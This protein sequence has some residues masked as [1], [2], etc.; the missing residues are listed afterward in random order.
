MIVQVDRWLAK[1]L[2]YPAYCCEF[3]LAD[4]G[5][6]GPTLPFHTREKSFLYCRTDNLHAVAELT[7]VGWILTETS[8]TLKTAPQSLRLGVSESFSQTEGLTD[9]RTA[10]LKDCQT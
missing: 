4:Y 10:E 6:A 2:G 9:R 1:Q 7:R 8:L 5:P 3:S